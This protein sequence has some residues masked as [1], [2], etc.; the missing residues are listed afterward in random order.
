VQ[1]S[2]DTQFH[3]GGSLVELTVISSAGTPLK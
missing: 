1:I 3:C 2:Y